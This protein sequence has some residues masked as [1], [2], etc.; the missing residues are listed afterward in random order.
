MLERHFGAAVI[1]EQR[2]YWELRKKVGETGGAPTP[3]KRLPETACDGRD[4]GGKRDVREDRTTF[5]RNC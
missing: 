3:F 1:E 2:R 5:T 4:A